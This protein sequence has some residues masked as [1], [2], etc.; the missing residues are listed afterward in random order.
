[1]GTCHCLIKH[2]ANKKQRDDIA[3]NLDY[4]RKVGD[5]R[6]T[7]LCIAQLTTKCAFMEEKKKRKRKDKVKRM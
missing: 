2:P 5:T 1:M 4:F 6:G 7:M 3:A